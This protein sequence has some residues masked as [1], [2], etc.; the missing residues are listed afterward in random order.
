MVGKIGKDL[1]VDDGYNAAKFC[2]L[3]IIATLKQHLGELSRVKRVVKINGFVNCT[4]DFTQ[5]PKVVNG[6]SD[7]MVA[8]FS[9]EIGT[10]ARAAVGTNSLPLGVAV[11][12]E[13]IVE[14]E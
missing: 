2:G 3:N 6:C 1:S 8:V 4:D 5:Q 14:V 13:A 7:V 10:H 11:E 9:Q 12:V